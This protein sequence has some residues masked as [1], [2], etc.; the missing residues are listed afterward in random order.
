MQLLLIEQDEAF[1]Q[2]VMA[3]L[4]QIIE[5][6]PQQ[7]VAVVTHGGVIGTFLRQALGLAIVRPGPLVVDNA[8]ISVFHVADDSSPSPARPR[9]QLVTLNDTCH[10]EGL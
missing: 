6:H 5:A 2:R 4:E 9:V 3:A 1:V 10:L 8:S 7:T